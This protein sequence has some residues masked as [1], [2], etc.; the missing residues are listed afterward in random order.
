MHSG[1]LNVLV[2]CICCGMIDFMSGYVCSKTLDMR[3]EVL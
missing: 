1:H 2:V 3:H